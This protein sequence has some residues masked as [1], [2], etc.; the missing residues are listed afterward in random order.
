MPLGPKP[1]PSAGPSLPAFLLRCRRSGAIWRRRHR[2]PP[3][4]S[5][6]PRRRVQLPP[7]VNRSRQAPP[8]LCRLPPA[9]PR[10]RARAGQSRH[11]LHGPGLA[12]GCHGLPRP[13]ALHS[14]QRFR[15]Y[16]GFLFLP[17]LSP[18]RCSPGGGAR[19]AAR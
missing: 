2:P 8:P 18:R 17:H 13:D 14:R 9:L 15:D 5:P 1:G 4:P 19:D 16:Q 10:I 3:S 6:T 11:G 7:G 12:L